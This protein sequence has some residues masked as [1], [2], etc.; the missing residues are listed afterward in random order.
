VLNE[1][2]KHPAVQRTHGVG[3]I[4]DDLGCRHWVYALANWRAGRVDRP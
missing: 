2:T 1:G 3:G 4:N